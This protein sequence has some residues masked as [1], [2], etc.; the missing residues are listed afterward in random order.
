M[1]N[2]E[3]IITCDVKDCNIN[4]KII[5]FL[6]TGP[7]GQ[8]YMTWKLPEGWHKYYHRIYCPEHKDRITETKSRIT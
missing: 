4:H 5:I 7:L 6:S 8:M 1:I 2:T 3:C